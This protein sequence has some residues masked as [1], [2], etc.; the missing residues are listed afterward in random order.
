MLQYLLMITIIFLNI[1][2]QQNQNDNIGKP[3]K[4]S[5]KCNYLYLGIY[6][7]Q[8]KFPKYPFVIPSLESFFRNTYQF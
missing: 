2:I 7:S 8:Q 4:K 5:T 1:I 6:P 3:F